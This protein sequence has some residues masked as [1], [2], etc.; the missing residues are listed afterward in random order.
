M[1]DLQ[2]ITKELEVIYSQVLHGRHKI[3][4]K[5]EMAN[6]GSKDCP[7]SRHALT[8]LVLKTEE[9]THFGVYVEHNKHCKNESGSFYPV[10]KF[11]SSAGFL[12][13][14]DKHNN[15]IIGLRYNITPKTS[16]YLELS[17]H[18][19]TEWKSPYVTNQTKNEITY[20]NKVLVNQCYEQIIPWVEQVL[21][22]KGL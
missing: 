20:A 5:S 11:T 1:K 16:F 18:P 19:H 4:K 22:A 13:Q 7:D 3:L 2:E 12:V 8:A 9:G 14:T 10:D 21:A 6:H 17:P 15:Q